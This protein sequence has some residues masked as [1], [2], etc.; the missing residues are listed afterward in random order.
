MTAACVNYRATG[1][2]NFLYIACKAAD[3]LCNTFKEPT[4]ALA[5]NLVCPTMGII[6]LYRTTHNLRYL[7]LAKKFLAMR[8]LVEDGTAD[9]QDQI[10]FDDQTQAEGHAV[11]ANYL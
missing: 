5:N 8:S 4:P 9:N 10:P 6:E 3:Y 2:T 1:E 7:E 11:R